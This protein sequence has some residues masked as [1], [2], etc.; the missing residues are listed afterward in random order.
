MAPKHPTVPTLRVVK[1]ARETHVAVLRRFLIPI[2][3][4][5]LSPLL[6][7]EHWDELLT[8][9]CSTG[10]AIGGAALGKS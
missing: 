7:E 9:A 4:L 3:I 1:A 10:G 6:E 2:L 8:A 5:T